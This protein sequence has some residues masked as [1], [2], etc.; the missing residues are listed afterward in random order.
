MI[1]FWMDNLENCCKDMDNISRKAVHCLLF[2]V[3]CTL[4]L[5][6]N[7]HKFLLK[8]SQIKCMVLKFLF[9]L[10]NLNLNLKLNLNL[11]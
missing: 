3:H 5:S 4:F 9:D 1:Y 11:N 7:A 10:L 2:F 6:T 8:F